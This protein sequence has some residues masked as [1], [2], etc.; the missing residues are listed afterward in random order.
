[1]EHGR[2]TNGAMPQ[3]GKGQREKK[4]RDKSTSKGRNRAV[5]SFLLWKRR[6]RAGKGKEEWEEVGEQKVIRACSG[7][8]D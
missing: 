4:G 1:M 2:A 7:G 3:P 6:K 8:Q 5:L